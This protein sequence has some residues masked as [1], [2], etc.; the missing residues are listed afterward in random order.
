M[1]RTSSAQIPF[2]K[3]YTVF[4]VDQ[5]EGLPE[6]FYAVAGA[7][8]RVA[9]RI[10]QAE[11]FFAATGADVRHGGDQAYYAPASPTTCRCRASKPSR[12]PRPTTRPCRTN[13]PTGP[14]TPTRLDRDFGRSACG[15]DRYAR[16]ELV[17]ELGAAFLCADLGIALS[18][19][20]GPRQLPGR[21]AE[22]A[23]GRPAA[24]FTAAAHAQRACDL[25]MGVRAIPSA[26]RSRHFMAVLLLFQGD[27]V[28]D[29]SPDD[30]RRG[31]LKI[32]CACA[33]AVTWTVHRPSRAWGRTRRRPIS[34]AG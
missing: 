21:L 17:A 15:D 16:E 19:A 29:P 22:G 30:G 2:L 8:A 3:A 18:P 34:V 28:P 31:D 24:I 10:A 5:I 14:G 6:H 32:T 20:R 26:G 12:T 7:E 1:A 27:D 11:A 4:N 23:E 13:A 33:H 9:R 25:P